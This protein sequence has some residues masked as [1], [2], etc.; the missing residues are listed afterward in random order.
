MSALKKWLCD[1]NS[2][3]VV[4]MLLLL[5][6]Q[7]EA[8]NTQQSEFG[9]DSNDARESS[10][11]YWWLQ[12]GKVVEQA[13]AGTSIQVAQAKLWPSEPKPNCGAEYYTKRLHSPYC[14]ATRSRDGTGEYS[15]YPIARKVDG[16]WKCEESCS[17]KRCCRA[18]STC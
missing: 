3:F 9:D 13:I 11:S 17:F 2:M 4:L 16:R 5:S 14:S 6:L 18:G 10:T 12:E 15:C 1:T 8:S 7:V